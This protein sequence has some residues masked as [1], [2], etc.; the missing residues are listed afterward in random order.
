MGDSKK[1]NF[2]IR[3]LSGSILFIVV[4]AAILASRYSLLALL[5]IICVGTMLEFYK[6]AHAQGS[7]PNR[8]LGVA[9]GILLITSS[10]LYTQHG[11]SFIQNE[12]GI[13]LLP[14][15]MLLIFAV[16]IAELFRKKEKPLANITATV[17]GVIYIALPL[18]LLCFLSIGGF[19]F[20]IAE[21]TYYRPWVLMSYIF[22]I[23]AND[24]GA[25]LAGVSMGRHKMFPRISPKKSW[26]GFAGGVVA[27][28][29]IAILCGWL[30]GLNVAFWAGLG[31]ITAIF[32][33]LG[34][35]VE[36]L[37]K[38]SIGVKDSGVMMPGHGGWLDRFDSL[39]IATPFV[40]VYFI[41][42]A[43]I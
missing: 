36:S 29:G 40:I 24:I 3:L 30:M 19:K 26:E 27:A 39:L 41:I 15:A 5:Y 6:L 1:N 8:P 16:F 18:S 2:L 28:I 12:I 17:C 21:S 14:F 34:D 35:L 13:L 25:Y 4:V 42:F 33:V 31:V 11:D 32:G 37:I 10:F 38:R 7:D 22:V 9:A 43:L 20:P 23:W